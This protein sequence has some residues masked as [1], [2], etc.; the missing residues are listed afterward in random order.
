LS[1]RE[2]RSF[3]H[4]VAGGFAN[5]TCK[6]VLFDPDHGELQNNLLGLV[7]SENISGKAIPLAVFKYF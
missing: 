3:T 5:R 7:Y 1:L 6:A 2:R 4:G